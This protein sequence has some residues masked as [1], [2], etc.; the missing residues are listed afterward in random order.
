VLR[1]AGAAGQPAWSLRLHD[2][3]LQAGCGLTTHTLE[4]LV[5]QT[6][7]GFS[8]SLLKSLLNFKDP[9]EIPA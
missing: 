3:M 1:A 6:P 2:A 5:R 8:R 4:P 9:F 7:V